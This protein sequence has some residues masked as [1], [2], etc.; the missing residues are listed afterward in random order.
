[1]QPLRR[2]PLLAALL[3]LPLASLPAQLPADPSGHW[4]GAI[5]APNMDVTIEVDL[6]KNTKGELAGTANIPA[7]NLKGLSLAN[8]AEKGRSVGFQIKGAPGERVFS[9]VLSADGKSIS[10]DYT[11]LGY[12]MPFTLTR[13]GE[14]GNEARA[15]S[16]PV[17]KELEG[18]WNATLAANGTERQLVLTLSNQPDGTADGNILNVEEGLEIPIDVITQKASRLTLD[19]KAIGGS[20]AGTLDAQGT[21]LAGTF[22][23]GSIALPLTF[24]RAAAGESTK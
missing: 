10:G 18:T 7:Q 8:F 3:L 17:A 14:P 24:R 23:Q 21:E 22:T 1:M 15:R 12:T 6:A 9:G 16:A 2:M 19:M 5:Q 11:Q 4:E 13:T 20:Y